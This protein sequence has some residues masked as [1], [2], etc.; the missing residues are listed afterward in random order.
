MW[1]LRTQQSKN[2]KMNKDACY[3][4]SEKFIYL[5]SSPTRAYLKGWS[6]WQT[7]AIDPHFQRC[8]VDAARGT[9]WSCSVSKT[10]GQS[11]SKTLKTFG[12]QVQPIA[13]PK[14]LTTDV[15]IQPIFTV[16]MYLQCLI[17]CGI[18]CVGLKH[19]LCNMRLKMP[20]PIDFNVIS[21]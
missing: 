16:L 5:I 10:G 17:C 6:S 4:M 14:I 13:L 20:L 12:N 19:I 2:M 18:L 3:I 9:A 1:S 11:H 21:V 7:A 8:T 15:K